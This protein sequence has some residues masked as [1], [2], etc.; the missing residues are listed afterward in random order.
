[1]KKIEMKKEIFRKRKI[2]VL[3]GSPKGNR[4]SVTMQFVH[5]AQRLFPEY[6]FKQI[7][8]GQKLT[9][10]KIKEETFQEIIKEIV[11]A[12]GVLWCYPV[13]VMLIPAQLKRFIELLFEN[14]APEILRGKYSAVLSTS[15]NFLDNAAFDY[16]HAIIEDLNMKHIGFFSG[17]MSSFSKI[18]KRKMWYLFIKNFLNTIENKLPIPRRF[19]SLV[20]REGFVFTP[21]VVSDE[22]K[23]DSA[24]KKIIILTDNIDEESNLGKMIWK[25]KESIKERIDIYNLDSIGMKA[26]CISCLNCGYDNQCIQKDGYSEFFQTKFKN[27]DIIVYALTIKDRYFS[28]QYKQF[29]D[30]MFCNGHIP[31]I[32]GAQLCYLISGP[33]SQIDNLRQL[34]TAQAEFGWGNSVGIITDEFGDSDEIN[35]LIYNMAK[36]AIKFSKSGYI[37]PPTF[38]NIGGYKLLRD[39]IYGL[40][41]VAFQADYRFYKKRGMFDFPKNQLSYRILRLVLKSEKFRKKFH[42]NFLQISI[43]PYEKFFEKLDINKEKDKFGF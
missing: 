32:E 24:G 36:Q 18:E 2:I 16:M 42:K 40:A 34:I 30:R 19:K 4:L 10:M 8:I 33:L 25:F 7:N 29:L 39:M 17:N 28:Y 20:N 6:D 22:L 13:F 37:Q 11:A 12:D 41:G 21:S 27:N 38:I 1:M 15:L 43:R 14:N 9:R 23:L 3:N 35:N 5:Y 26:G 31:F